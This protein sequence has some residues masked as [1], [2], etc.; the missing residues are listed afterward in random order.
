MYFCLVFLISINTKWEKHSPFFH[1]YTIVRTWEIS[2][3][4]VCSLETKPHQRPVPGF[5]LISYTSCL[6]WQIIV[7]LWENYF[8]STPYPSEFNFFPIFL[9][10]ILC[11]Y[12]LVFNITLKKCWTLLVVFPSSFFFFKNELWV[13]EYENPQQLFNSIFYLYNVFLAFAIRGMS[14]C[15]QWRSY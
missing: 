11:G 12:K 9:S 5:G 6:L 8:H 15:Y 3:S 14:H 1:L 4:C 10:P 7:K 13:A 2:W